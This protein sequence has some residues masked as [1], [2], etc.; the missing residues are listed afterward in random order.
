MK[1]LL[2]TVVAVFIGMSAAFAQNS[3]TVNFK[4]LPK[5]IQ[6][7]IAKNYAGYTVDK[8]MQEQ[9]AKG[10]VA[11]TDVYISKG[12]E[13]SKLIFDKKDEFV[14]KVPVTADAKAPADTTKK[15]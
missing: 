6:K 14:K 1:K 8:A 2:I 4:E 11:F 9:N 15:Q 10:D 5:D 12:T 7:Y 3:Y 13:K